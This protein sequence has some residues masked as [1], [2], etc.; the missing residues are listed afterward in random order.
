MFLDL[1][2][3]IVVTSLLSLSLSLSLSLWGLSRAK[4][5]C[6]LGHLE[7]EK[8][9]WQKHSQ[10]KLELTSLALLDPHSHQR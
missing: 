8:H 10:Q 4:E 6:C 3:A 7:Q 1:T 9:F 2:K 5:F